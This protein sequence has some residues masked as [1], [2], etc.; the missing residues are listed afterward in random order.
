MNTRKDSI[1]YK[2]VLKYCCNRT[3]GRYEQAIHYGRLSDYFTI[4][5]RLTPRGRKMAQLPKD[6]LAA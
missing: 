6:G 1:D 3:M 2:A 5:N 4:D